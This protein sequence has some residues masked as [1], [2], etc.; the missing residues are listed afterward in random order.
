MLLVEKRITFIPEK[1]R[2]AVGSVLFKSL[3]NAEK[4]K[5]KSFTI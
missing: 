2:S 4:N 5:K 3:L 1:E